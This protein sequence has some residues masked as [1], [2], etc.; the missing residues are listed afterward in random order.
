MTSISTR[1]C[2]TSAG[3]DDAGARRTAP[4]SRARRT[5]GRARSPVNPQTSTPST[6]N[7]G[8]RTVRPQ[9][10]VLDA[11]A[12]GRVEQVR[13][14]DAEHVHRLGVVDGRDLRR[15]RPPRGDRRHQVVA[16]RHGQRRQG[17]EHLDARRVEARPP[18]PPRAAR[19]RAGRRR[20]ARAARR[21]R[22]S[23]RRGGRR[24]RDRRCS[25]TSRSRATAGEPARAGVASS[26]PNSTSTAAGRAVDGVLQHAGRVHPP[27]DAARAQVDELGARAPHVR[28][29]VRHPRARTSSPKRGEHLRRGGTSPGRCAA[30]AARIS[31]TSSGD[32]SPTM[33][34]VLSQRSSIPA[35][36]SGWNCTPERAAGPERLHRGRRGRGQQRGARRA[37]R[38]CRSASAARSGRSPSA[39]S[40]RSSAT[41]STGANPISVAARRCSRE[42]SASASSCM[43]EAHAQHRDVGVDRRGEQRTLGREPG[44][45]RHV[46]GVHRAAHDDDAGHLVERREPGVV[47][48]RARSAPGSGASRPR[49]DQPRA[50]RAARA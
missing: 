12:V 16:H 10:R 49:R 37:G 5:S 30:P 26:A 9:R 28:R 35:S 31:S 11:R 6:V 18:R 33:S 25:S 13:H 7:A 44:M 36:S 8:V 45:A 15:A 43:P 2:T 22:R 38:P 21:G 34:G 42:P 19:P 3:L 17:A 47:A 32:R 4:P 24:V 39:P 40:T 23:A 1:G 48:G 46:V 41:T 27:V 20:T 50:P 14:R 29:R